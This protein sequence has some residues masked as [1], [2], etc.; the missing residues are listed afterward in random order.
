MDTGNTTRR[1]LTLSR[2]LTP[3]ALLLAVSAVLVACSASFST[4]HISSAVLAKDV[5]AR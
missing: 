5:S 4:A 1:G 3:I 2:V